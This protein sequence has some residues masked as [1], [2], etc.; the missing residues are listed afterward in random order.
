MEHNSSYSTPLSLTSQ[1]PFCGLPLRLDTYLGCTFGCIY[2]SSK[3]RGGNYKYV[4]SKPANPAFINNFL[5]PPKEN[6][7]VS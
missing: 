4:V 2:C 7:V 6:A 1:F 3:D 5:L